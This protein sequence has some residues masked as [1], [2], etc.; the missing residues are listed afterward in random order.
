M[1]QKNWEVLAR[2]LVTLNNRPSISQSP[3]PLAAGRTRNAEIM[4]FLLD[5]VL[6]KPNFHS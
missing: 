4:G 3:R 5:M 2:D 6:W 1:C